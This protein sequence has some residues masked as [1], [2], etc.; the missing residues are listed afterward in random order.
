LGTLKAV[1]MAVKLVVLSA[2]QMVMRKAGEMVD[3]WAEHLA[4][5]LAVKLEWQ[6]AV[7]TAVKLGNYLVAPLVVLT[8][9]Q[10]G[11]WKAGLLAQMKAVSKAELKV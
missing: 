5:K 10:M 6:R 3:L 1:L 9:W 11:H 7:Q 8:E 2:D 4:N